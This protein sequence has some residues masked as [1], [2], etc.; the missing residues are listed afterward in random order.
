MLERPTQ[1]NMEQW[2]TAYPP[3]K[4]NHQVEGCG[5]AGCI[6]GWSIFLAKELVRL[7]DAWTID[8]LPGRARETLGLN[9]QEAY[10]LF[11]FSGWPL[12]FQEALGRA[13]NP[14]EYASVVAR[15]I[16]HFIEH[17]Q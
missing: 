10:S 7:S 2:I 8:D 1:V 6:A 5:T 4:L 16:E 3:I 12:E 13:N 11:Y 17:K 9:H 15:R 14:V